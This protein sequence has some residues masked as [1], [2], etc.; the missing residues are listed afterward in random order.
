MNITFPRASIAD[1]PALVDIQIRA[2]HDDTRLYGVPLDGPPGYD[3]VD[4]L[5]KKLEQDLCHKVIY[6]DKIV[7][8]I[9]VYDYGEGHFHLDVIAI[10]PDYHNQGIG[11]AAMNYIEAVYP[12]VK[13]TL[14]TPLYA[15][16]NQHFYEKFG[17]QKI[18][19]FEADGITLISYEKNSV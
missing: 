3:S 17:Y 7:G 12:A 4:S 14:D 13:W 6:D 1:A 5:I 19:E 9:I 11:T 15:I 16:R 8:D 18:E 2:F 10:D